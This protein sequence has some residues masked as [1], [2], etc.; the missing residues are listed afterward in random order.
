MRGSGCIPLVSACA[1]PLAVAAQEPD[2]IGRDRE[3]VTADIEDLTAEHRRILDENQIPGAS[4]ALVEKDRTISYA[5][6][7]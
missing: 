2:R 3:A 7:S 4:V 5:W 1:L 6:D